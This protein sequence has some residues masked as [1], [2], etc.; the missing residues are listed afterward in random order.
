MCGRV[1]QSSGP[2]RYGIV[3]GTDVHDS[4]AHNYPPRWNAAPSQDLLVIRRNHQTGKI[5][6]DP[7]FRW[8]ASNFKH[9]AQERGV[10]K[11]LSTM[12]AGDWR[13]D[14]HNCLLWN[15][16]NATWKFDSN[17]S[18]A[19]P[20]ILSGLGTLDP[21]QPWLV[22]PS[23]PSIFGAI[24]FVSRHVTRSSWRALPTIQTLSES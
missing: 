23:G 3:E 20:Q 9:G 10:C 2:L 11:N 18:D 24:L 8:A 21:L 4:R 1:I 6:L 22:R 15:G 16:V 12:D 19:R 14:S 17:F 7:L 5:S 13:R